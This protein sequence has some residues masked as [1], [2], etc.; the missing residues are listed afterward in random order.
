MKKIRFLFLFLAMV[1]VSI[2][3]LLNCKSKTS[4][5]SGDK[6]GSEA[7]TETAGPNQLTQA[8]IDDGWVLLFD[9]ETS[10][11]WRSV[12]KETFPEAG[13]DIEDGSLHCLGSGKGEAV[14]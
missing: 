4:G 13:W 5:E 12:N 6:A 3:V 14:L 10:E 9:G 11:G 2:L 8:E 1:V 7:V